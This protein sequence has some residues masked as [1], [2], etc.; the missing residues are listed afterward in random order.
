MLIGLDPILSP[1]LLCILR[2]MGHGDR[3]VIADANFPA[4]SC[5]RKL[6]RL[7]GVDAS[8]ALSAILSIMPLDSYVDDPAITMQ[9]VGD[10]EAVPEAVQDFQRI[11]NEVADAPAQITTIERFSFYEAAK[12]TFAIV[13]TGE[14]RFY[15]NIILTKGVISV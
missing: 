5:A 2:A 10:P 15:G 9:V 1:Q 8:R 12:S 4:E 11:V 3:I 13:Q 6:V 7:D 14:R